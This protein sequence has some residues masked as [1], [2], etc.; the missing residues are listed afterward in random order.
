MN[1]ANKWSWVALLGILLAIL[2]PAFSTLGTNWFASIRLLLFSTHQ[3]LDGQ[4]EG[5]LAVK[6]EG[7]IARSNM[8]G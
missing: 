5:K 8:E 6:F 4:F 3:N 7:R 2:L 1:F